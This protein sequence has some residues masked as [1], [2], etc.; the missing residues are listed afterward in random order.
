MLQFEFESVL[1]VSVRQDAVARRH[2]ADGFL[3]AVVNCPVIIFTP[4]KQS[5]V[6][7]CQHQADNWPITTQVYGQSWFI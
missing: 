4:S 3:L 2:F 5:C 7:L 1:S 6:T